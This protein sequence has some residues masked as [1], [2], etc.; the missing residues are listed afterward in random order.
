VA[1]FEQYPAYLR[2]LAQAIGRSIDLQAFDEAAWHT[3]AQTHTQT[4]TQCDK[5][6]ARFE[7][8]LR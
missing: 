8:V 2:E 4:H 6:A 3:Q 7:L 5:Q 1:W